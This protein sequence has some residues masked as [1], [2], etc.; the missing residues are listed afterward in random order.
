[1]KL[2]KKGPTPKPWKGT[3]RGCNSKFSADENELKVVSDRDGSFAEK[4]C[5][6][7]GD[8]V[9]FYPPKRS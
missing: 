1:M 5:T 6:E 8:R 7:C 2:I 9:F 3:C 4:K